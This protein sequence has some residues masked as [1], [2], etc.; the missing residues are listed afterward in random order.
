MLTSVD[1]EY[2]ASFALNITFILV[3]IYLIFYIDDA[4]RPVVSM[5]MS[6]SPVAGSVA[7]WR[8]A[9]FRRSIAY[10][11]SS[12]DTSL[13]NLILAKASLILI[14]D[15]SILGVATIVN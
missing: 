11:A 6:I 13:D 8:V 3:Y 14:K 15:S 9:K 7:A 4:V 12:P 2:F 5:P 10:F 1:F